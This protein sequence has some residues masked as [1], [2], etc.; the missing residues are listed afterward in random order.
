M[1]IVVGGRHFWLFVL[2]DGRP[3][4]LYTYL[5]YHLY[6]LCI[7]TT[8]HLFSGHAQC[9]KPA[10]EPSGLGQAPLSASFLAELS[11][12]SP[13]IFVHHLY[14]YFLDQSIRK[15][16]HKFEKGSTGA[17]ACP[18]CR[19]GAHVEG[20]LIARGGYHLAPNHYTSRTTPESSFNLCF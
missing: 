15:T 5:I 10:R 16:L 6:S 2:A 20:V 8:I 19:A 13:Q 11:V 18:F 4:I 7:Y 12:R 17:N 3:Y 1:T 14:K 9:Q